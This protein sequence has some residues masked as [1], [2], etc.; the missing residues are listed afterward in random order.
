[1]SFEN[2]IPLIENDVVTGSLIGYVTR[3]VPEFPPGKSLE[4][5]AKLR[6]EKKK[7][8]RTSSV[9]ISEVPPE[10]LR[11]DSNTAT[12]TPNLSAASST[13]L[14]VKSMISFGGKLPLN[15]VPS[16]TTTNSN[17]QEN[18]LKSTR[19]VRNIERLPK[20]KAEWIDKLEKKIKSLESQ[21][22]DSSNLLQEERDKSHRAIQTA[23]KASVELKQCQRQQKKVTLLHDA[24]K[25]RLEHA[26]E[27][28]SKSDSE[29]AR[30]KK[31]LNEVSHIARSIE[32]KESNEKDNL[33][34]FDDENHKAFPTKKRVLARPNK[35]AILTNFE[36]ESKR[37]LSVFRGVCS[38]ITSMAQKEIESI[39]K[40][41][42]K[43]DR[44]V[45]NEKMK[46]M[47]ALEA[48]RFITSPDAYNDINDNNNNKKSLKSA[49]RVQSFEKKIKKEKLNQKRPVSRPVVQKNDVPISFEKATVTANM[50]NQKLPKTLKKGVIGRPATSHSNVV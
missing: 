4:N 7:I 14:G 11:Y 12:N 29:I 36:D 15:S 23:F 38:G 34:S 2:L 26:L 44:Y 33:L 43:K 42:P 30:L 1:M 28:L 27:M 45:N 13:Q 17:L 32:E 49:V 37:L 46:L 3:Y 8:L 5:Q 47:S 22:R 9:L 39:R 21:I 6:E 31:L 18:K 10:K 35:L 41:A 25:K 50:H 48:M 40:W 24:T 16:T 20:T 19:S